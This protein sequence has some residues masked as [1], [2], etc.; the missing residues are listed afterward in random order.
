[1]HKI[2]PS[3][4]IAL[5]VSFG[6][7]V[8]GFDASVISGVVS[9]VAIEFNLTDWQQ[10]FVVSSPTL[11]AVIASSVAGTIS[12]KV[13]RKKVLL[14]IAL[15]YVVSAVCSTFANSYEMLIVSRFLGGMAFSSLILA[16]VY[17]AEISEAKQRGKMISI[18]QFNIVIGLS[19]AYFTNYFLVDLMQ[20]ESALATSINLQENIWRWMLGLEILPAMLFFIGLFFIPE[21]PR[22]LVMKGEQQKAKEV[23]TKLH[24][25]ELMQVELNEIEKTKQ[26]KTPNLLASFKEL[27]SKK[28]RLV[29]LIGVTVAIF[30]QVTGVNAIY[31]YA[32]SIFEQSGVG[33]NAAFAQAVWVG[34]INVIFTII[35]MLLIDKV[36]RK[37]LLNVGLIGIAL[38]MILCF[39]GFNN[40]TYKL[41][42]NAV[43]TL[44]INQEQLQP[45]VNVE[46]NDD[47]EF[48]QALTDALGKQ[49]FK[50]HE[51]KLIQSAI[52]IEATFVLAGILGFVASFAV[53][54]GPVMWVLLAE[55]FPNHLRGI[56]ISVVGVIN[57]AISFSI[58]LIFPWQLSNLGTALTFLL[59]GLFAVLGFVLISYLLPETKGKTLEQIEKKLVS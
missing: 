28:M 26:A 18:N 3:L 37:P 45:I 16:P 56:A 38:S 12:D 49:E 47:L 14:V 55:I 35:A 2:S 4:Y 46:F 21:S 5:M 6:G 51:A 27:F 15:L 34:L 25:A 50:K 17:I 23:L 44:E 40:A 22:Y 57:S 8:F 59:Y 7:F 54:L 42:P 10:G 24:G 11:G 36:G 53:S 41:T 19:A 39:I 43:Q 33:T 58:Q 29:M 48:K 1:M 20:S 52:N 13:G 32:P 9:F 30:Q 31:F